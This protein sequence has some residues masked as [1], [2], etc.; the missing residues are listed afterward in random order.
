MHGQSGSRP[1]LRRPWPVPRLLQDVLQHRHGQ[2]ALP[3]AYPTESYKYALVY[4]YL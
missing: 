4:N 2:A 3:G 1:V